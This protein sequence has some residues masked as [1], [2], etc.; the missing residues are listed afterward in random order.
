MQLLKA[1]TAGGLGGAVGTG[2]MTAVMVGVRRA[3]LVGTPELPPE[4]VTA[5]MLNQA[6]IPRDDHT[7]D[8]LA[9]AAHLAFGSGAGVVFGLLS[10]NLRPPISRPLQGILFGAALWTSSYAGW[11]PALALLPPPPRDSPLR[12]SLLILEHL[13]YGAVLGATVELLRRQ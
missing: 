11:V 13:V 10:L 6:R 4:Q 1:I 8:A 2:A 5:G 3:G 9:A 7:Q 12:Q